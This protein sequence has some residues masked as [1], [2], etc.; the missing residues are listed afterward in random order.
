MTAR[1]LGERA[2]F[3]AKALRD[4][5]GKLKEVTSRIKLIKNDINDLNGCAANLVANPGSGGLSL[6]A[7]PDTIVDHRPQSEL[8]QLNVASQYT[9]LVSDL[10]SLVDLPE[11]WWPRKPSASPPGLVAFWEDNRVEKAALFEMAE[12][13]LC[14]P[15]ASAEAERAFSAI[16]RLLSQ[17]RTALTAEH[18][19]AE[20]ILHFNKFD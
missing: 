16:N 8:R 11:N 1:G 7:H 5:G 9:R 20:V 17:Q 13:L 19:F 4:K 18:L 10:V 14:I 3:F 6:I 12:R 15:I 2:R